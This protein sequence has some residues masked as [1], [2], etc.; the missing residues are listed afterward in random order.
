LKELFRIFRYISSHP[1]ASRRKSVAYRRFFSW[2]IAQALLK[3]PILYPFVEDSV[4]LIEKGM[5]GATGNIYTG[6]LEFADM[7]FVLHVLRSGDIFGDVGANVGVYTI[8]A[9]RNAGARVFSVE[10]IPSTVQKLR[11]NVDLNEVS[12][13]VVI[14]PYVAGDGSGPGVVRFT[15]TMDTV[16]HV[17]RDG[18]QIDW[19]DTVE[20]PVKT[21]DELLAGNIPAVIKIDV[22]GFEW[23][24]LMGAKAILASADLKAIII[25][26]NR[27]GVAYGYSDQQIHE[28][29]LSFQFSP[30]AYD[31]FT[32]ALRQLSTFG[33]ENTI[34]IKDTAW[35]THRVQT[36]RKFNILGEDV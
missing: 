8:L 11:R 20:I 9:A 35:I 7:A 34:Y 6:L 16:N 31:P 30:Y 17:I 23:P 26:L 25:E 18:E 14:L 21:L 2:Q 33:N 15:Q 1:L 5:T 19:K 10:P 32:R 24:A 22:E 29:L 4:L 12:E 36:A 3:R 13:R 27:S 28:L